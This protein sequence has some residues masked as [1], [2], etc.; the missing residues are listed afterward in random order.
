MCPTP[1]IFVTNYRHSLFFLILTRSTWPQRIV[2]NWCACAAF[3]ASCPVPA[4]HRR[5]PVGR[6]CLSLEWALGGAVS[7]FDREQV[8]GRRRSRRARRHADADSRFKAAQFGS[9]TVPHR[10]RLA[11]TQA[12]KRL[13]VAKRSLTLLDSIS[14]DSAR[15]QH[16][17]GRRGEK[18]ARRPLDG[19]GRGPSQLNPAS[20]E[21]GRRGDSAANTSLQVFKWG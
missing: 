9:D 4:P 13:E 2:A 14:V 15:A 10:V 7:A 1:V 20:P 12:T 19:R 3:L 17:H 18:D 16:A 21:G 11:F 6:A 5:A 8:L